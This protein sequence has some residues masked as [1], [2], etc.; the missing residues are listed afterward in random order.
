[1]GAWATHITEQ[2]TANLELFITPSGIIIINEDSQNP[3]MVSLTI[4][5]LLQGYNSGTAAWGRH[6]GLDT[7]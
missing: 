6:T 7:G 3:E 2:L 4:T 1:M 5:G